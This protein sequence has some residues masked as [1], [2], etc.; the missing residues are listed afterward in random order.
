MC[1]KFYRIGPWSWGLALGGSVCK[2][3]YKKIQKMNKIV[4]ATSNQINEMVCEQQMSPIKILR[5]TIAFVTL[6]EV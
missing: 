4:M 1:K 6:L 2:K 5:K 3:K